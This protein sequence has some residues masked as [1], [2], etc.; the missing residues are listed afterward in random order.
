MSSLFFKSKYF[1]SLMGLILRFNITCNLCELQKILGQ[2]IFSP[3]LSLSPNRLDHASYILPF[4]PFSLNFHPDM[5]RAKNQLH[6]NQLQINCIPSVSLWYFRVSQFFG[7]FPLSINPSKISEPYIEIFSLSPIF[8]TLPSIYILILI[9]LA[10]FPFFVVE[11]D[12]SRFEI[13][14]NSFHS[15]GRDSFRIINFLGV[16]F[17]NL[18]PMLARVDVLFQRGKFVQFWHNFTQMWDQFESRGITNSERLEIYLRRRLI[19]HVI[20][21]GFCAV[22]AI[23]GAIRYG[24]WDGNFENISVTSVLLVG[25]DVVQ[26]FTAVGQAFGLTLLIF[27]T[28]VYNHC[29]DGILDKVGKLNVP[30]FVNLYKLLDDQVVEF[31]DVFNQKII[32]EVFYNMVLLLFFGY[33]TILF[34]KMGEI[35][36]VLFN[37]YNVVVLFVW[38]FWLGKLCGDITVKSGRIG[39]FLMYQSC[40][41]SGDYHGFGNC[42]GGDKVRKKNECKF[43]GG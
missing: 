38:F 20:V 3:I 30:E 27:F 41:R 18:S 25:L 26:N 7:F 2:N 21:N 4:F 10:I 29:L 11:A 16:T 40:L 22:L 9:G 42:C 43:F 5:E 8:R 17:G 24:G 1:I 39:K 14:S 6:K 15:V 23:F 12:I 19:G 36:Y 13:F 37:L 34:Y 35:M 32:L 31:N 28:Q 33:F